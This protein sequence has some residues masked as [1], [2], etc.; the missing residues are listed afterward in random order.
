[1]IY[2]LQKAVSR[3][4][5]DSDSM[6]ESKADASVLLPKENSGPVPLSV[7]RAKQL[8]SLFTMVQNP[9]MTH[10]KLG[11]VVVL[12]PLWIRCDGSDPEHT[13]W[14]GAEP[15]KAG[16]KIMGINLHMVTC[17]GP[18]A[19][20]TCFANLGELKMQHKIMHHSSVVTTKG[21]AQYELLRAA[22]LEDTIVESEINICV[23]ITWNTVD[24]ILDTPPLISAATLNIA[25]EPG[26]PRS[27]V[28]QLYRELQFLLA[29]AEGLKTG[30]TKWP[31]PLEPE[32]AVELV[33][34]FLADL[35]RKL[36]GCCVSGNRDGMEKIQCDTEAVDSSIKSIFSER[37]DLDF[38]EQLWC[39]MKCVSS[40]Q[41]LMACFTL[42]LESLERGEIQPWIH[43]GS[44][45]LLSKLI[46]QSYH[47]KM[48][49]VSLTGITPIQMLLEIGLDK[50]K[51]DYVNFFIGQELAT[52]T[53]LDYFISTSVDLQ[54]QVHR[55]QK[56][57]H[58]LEIMVSC[59]VLLQLK[60]ENLFP[61]TQICMK[62][63]RENPLD[64]KHVFQLPIGSALVKKFYQDSP[65]EV[66]KVDIS[67]GHGPKEVKTSW[68]V[69]TNPPVEHMTSNNTSFL[70][71]STV[72]AST[73]DRMYFITVVKC[74][75]VHFR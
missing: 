10:L 64:E 59:T 18:T 43:Q 39:K 8:I 31:E 32:S 53:Y 15:L 16:N 35:K 9:N 26:D 69:S 74:S 7:R 5:E 47:G 44:S 54:E 61:L 70:S 45:S 29:L 48:E 20:K 75:Q 46:Q 66:W 49:A 22:A 3:P 25:L 14:L 38:A 41:E 50:M 72:N 68:Q 73:Q 17:D 19:D 42:I 40:Y 67:S 62:Y 52:L 2:V 4:S 37:G 71:D 51:K 34:E 12:P 36:D 58:M 30:V 23:D 63:Y 55:V 24:K 27:P 6:E 57:H 60:H 13:C 21:F 28:Y 65:P 11:E 1:M 33:Q 56:L